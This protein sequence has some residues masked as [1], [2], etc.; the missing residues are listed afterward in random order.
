MKVA[1]NVSVTQAKKRENERKKRPEEKKQG[2][3]RQTLHSD[4]HGR[5]LALTVRDCLLTDKTVLTM[6]APLNAG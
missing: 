1:F 3:N 2:V 6:P 5:I 4:V